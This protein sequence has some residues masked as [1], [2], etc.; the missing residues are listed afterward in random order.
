MEK[1]MNELVYMLTECASLSARFRILDDLYDNTYIELEEAYA[2]TEQASMH[3]NQLLRKYINKD[4]N[5][6]NK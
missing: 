4:I 5:E 1:L 3:I 6:V 2:D